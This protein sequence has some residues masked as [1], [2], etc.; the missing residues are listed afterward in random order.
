MA[1]L[2]GLS[3][4]AGG[5]LDGSLQKTTVVAGDFA[6]GAGWGGSTLAVTAGSTDQRG[7]FTITCA[8]GGG[9]AQATATVTFTFKDGAFNAAPWPIAVSSNDNSVDTGRFALTSV[10]TTA[11]VW[12]FSVLPV[13]TKVY[14]CQ[15][16]IIA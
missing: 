10:T 1:Q 9:L 2:Q 8:T 6:L 15:Y 12:T 14:R 7:E 16:A 11:A 3:S 13:N 5:R 4:A